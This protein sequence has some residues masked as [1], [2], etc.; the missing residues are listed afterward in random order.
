MI[1]Q[2]LLHLVKGQRLVQLIWLG[3]L[4]GLGRLRSRFVRA[5]GFLGRPLLLLGLLI[6]PLFA[7]LT[8]LLFFLDL[9]LF[10]L[11]HIRL[12][13]GLLGLGRSLRISRFAPLSGSTTFRF[14]P[15]HV[16]DHRLLDLDLLLGEGR[17]PFFNL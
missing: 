7:F 10:F 3:I 11:P 16:H 12:G 13:F 4:L 6:L 5:L 2:G 1:L 14:E 15:E 17:L 9:I 8:L